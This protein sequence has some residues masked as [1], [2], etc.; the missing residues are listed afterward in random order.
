MTATITPLRNHT[1]YAALTRTASELSLPRLY[2]T[3]LT[4]HDRAWCDGHGTTPFLWAIYECG[5]HLVPLDDRRPPNP[6]RVHSEWV[7]CIATTFADLHWFWW[8]GTELLPLR[9]AEH[10]KDVCR[11]YDDAYAADQQLM[12][13]GR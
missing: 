13:G 1:P 10:A 8:N 12:R 2:K 6:F 9:D 11:E 4:T 5:T 3:D 7:H